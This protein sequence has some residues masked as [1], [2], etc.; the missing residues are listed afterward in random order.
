MRLPP[1]VL[2]RAVTFGLNAFTLR[3]L[4]RELLGVVNVRWGGG[5]GAPGPGTPGL[6]LSVSGVGAR[7]LCS[8]CRVAKNALL[9]AG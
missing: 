1:Q 9:N 3:Y 2:F 4:S 8:A 7:G 5:C 6:L